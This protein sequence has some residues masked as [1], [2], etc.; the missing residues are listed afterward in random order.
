MKR[1][2]PLLLFHLFLVSTIIS[3]AQLKK[4]TPENALFHYLELKDSSYKW[5]LKDSFRLGESTIYRLLLTSQ[6][7]QNILW[8]HELIIINPGLLKYNTALLFISGGSIR[9]GIPKWSSESD[10]LIKSLSHIAIQNQSCVAMIS[11]V[12][13][14]PLFNGMVEDQIISYTL[15]KFQQ[16]HDYTLPLLFPMVKSAQQAMT[17]VQEFIRSCKEMDIQHF[18]VSGASKRGWTTWLAGASDKRIVAI[19][20]MVIDILNMPVS[21]NYQ[22]QTWKDYSVEIQDYVKLGIPQQSMTEDGRKL[23]AM[24]DPYSYRDKLNMPKMIFMGG[25]DPY[26]VIDNIKNYYDSLP[27]MNLLQ[28][29]PNAGHNLGTKEQAFNTLNAFLAFTVQGINY[30]PLSWKINS[31]NRRLNITI[32]TNDKAIGVKVWE[33][34]SNDADIRNNVWLP[35]NVGYENGRTT[36]SVSQK[37][38]EKGYK[39]FFAAVT[40]TSPLGGTYDQMTRVFLMDTTGLI[41]NRIPDR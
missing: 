1:I 29:V 4:V 22:I 32:T 15:H 34:N 9:D 18:V 5:E 10:G 41:D 23:L 36:F 16:T 7:W 8:K 25:N 21:L 39:A 38:P 3:N 6:K 2:R 26:W 28:Y 19:A 24:I 13:N 14:Q 27:G 30:N 40:Y 31:G 33:A 17:A 35:V 20:P 11:Q 37:F 12:P